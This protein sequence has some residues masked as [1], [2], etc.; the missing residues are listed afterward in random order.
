MKVAL[1]LQRE[2]DFVGV[3]RLEEVGKISSTSI[4]KVTGVARETSGTAFDPLNG[5]RLPNPRVVDAV[6][7]LFPGEPQKIVRDR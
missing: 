7:V 4:Y 1:V 2:D 3:F 6:E 5:S